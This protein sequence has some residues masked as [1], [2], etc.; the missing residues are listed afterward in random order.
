MISELPAPAVPKRSRKMLRFE[1]HL[2]ASGTHHI[3]GIDEAGRG[4]LAGPVVAAAVI[5]PHDVVLRGVKDSKVLTAEQREAMYNEIFAHALAVGVGQVES[6]EIDRI[7]ILNATYKAMH[8][9]IR[10]LAIPPDHLLIDGNRFLENG[11]PFTTVIDG[12]ALSFSVAA[13][14]IVAKVTRDRLMVGYD[15]LYPAYGFAKHK[16]Y[17]TRE[18]REAIIKCGF[19]PIH[20]QSFSVSPLEP[21]QWELFEDD[22]VGDQRNEREEYE[23]TTGT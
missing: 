12:D 2:W 10:R 9:A 1:R 5:F 13:A 18:H 21:D 6:E 16:G 8:E 3:A 20:R 15:S 4:P 22:G 17:A 23:A 14:S 7:N 19:C 11:I